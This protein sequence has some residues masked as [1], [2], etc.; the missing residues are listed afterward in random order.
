M[1]LEET[2]AFCRKIKPSDCAAKDLWRNHGGHEMGEVLVFCF[3]FKYE[4]KRAL[5][6]F[7]NSSLGFRGSNP[8]CHSL[9]SWVVST[10]HKARAARQRQEHR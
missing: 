4:W 10:Y 2:F 9:K 8:K 3:I 1:L 6:I 7:R 5:H